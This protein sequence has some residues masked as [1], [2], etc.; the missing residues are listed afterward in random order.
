MNIISFIL[1]IF[2]LVMMLVA[3][4][5]FMFERNR[6]QFDGKV[7]GTIVGSCYNSNEFNHDGEHRYLGGD[8]RELD[9]EPVLATT[10]RY[11]VYR[12]EINGK[13]YMRADY[14][15]G[16]ESDIAKK[17][18]KPIAVY[19]QTKNP[20]CSTLSNG[21]TLRFIGIILSAFSFLFLAAAAFFLLFI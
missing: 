4:C 10:S 2:G 20:G 17:M 1:L 16:N 13:T 14:I 15:M 12:Y 7:S 9:V 21:R 6:R 19:Y 18:H 3:F 11:P 5:F 8:T